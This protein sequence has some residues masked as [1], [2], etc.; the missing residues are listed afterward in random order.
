VAGWLV[1]V[2]THL[3]Q[4]TLEALDDE[5]HQRHKV[6]EAETLAP[7]HGKGVA[8]AR[9][10]NELRGWVRCRAAARDELRSASER[11]TTAAARDGGGCAAHDMTHLLKRMTET[12]EP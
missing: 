12:L 8:R 6:W 9:N 5:I 1:A 4:S 7:A 10:H 2:M 11:V 3:Q